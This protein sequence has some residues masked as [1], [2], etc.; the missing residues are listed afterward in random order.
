MYSPSDGCARSIQRVSKQH[1]HRGQHDCRPPCE[2]DTP[3]RR[4][5]SACCSAYCSAHAL[6]E[7]ARCVLQVRL[8]LEM[9]VEMLMVVVPRVQVPVPRPP[10]SSC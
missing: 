2:R 10:R 9:V 4:R 1:S 5:G 3:S 7:R 8:L 6:R